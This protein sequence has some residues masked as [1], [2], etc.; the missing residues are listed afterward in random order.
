M[1]G[2]QYQLESDVVILPL[3]I[4]ASPRRP[5][6]GTL[7]SRLPYGDRGARR[8]IVKKQALQAWPSDAPITTSKFYQKLLQETTAEHSD[9]EQRRHEEVQWMS[10]CRDDP[11]S[12]RRNEERARTLMDKAW[13][14]E[15]KN[16]EKTKA[17]QGRSCSDG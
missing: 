11:R 16:N 6:L 15:A 4:A 10:E 5:A 8:L 2:S 3:G 7:I 1:H 17:T 13:L 9:G 14:L 12:G